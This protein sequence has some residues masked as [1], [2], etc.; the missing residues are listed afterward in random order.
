[1]YTRYHSVEW[2][3]QE[4]ASK[5][6][7]PF[8]LTNVVS[9]SKTKRK[10]IEYLDLSS[11]RRPVPHRLYRQCFPFA[12]WFGRCRRENIQAAESQ[13]SPIKDPEDTNADNTEHQSQSDGEDL[14][15]DL[16]LL[17]INRLRVLSGGIG[18]R[19]LLSE[20]SPELLALSL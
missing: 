18:K 14:S 20:E 11:E 13:H 4:E 9:V 8:C 2:W 6:D 3:A 12:T 17:R 19:S 16:F 15:T 1:M 10:I 7:Y 5:T